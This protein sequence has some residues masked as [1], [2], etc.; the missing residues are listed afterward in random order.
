MS[1]VC[2]GQVFGC[3]KPWHGC[4]RSSRAQERPAGPAAEESRAQERFGNAKSISSA[5]FNA[6]SSENSSQDRP[7]RLS[8]FQTSASISS[9]DYFGRDE[10]GNGGS[11]GPQPGSPDFDISATELMSK[12]S[13]Q[14]RPQ[15]SICGRVL[16]VVSSVAGCR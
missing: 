13:M 5:Q 2:L 12:L 14:A 8:R 1:A 4:S 7:S 10:G 3:I 16:P 9:S 15:H 11:R 6:E